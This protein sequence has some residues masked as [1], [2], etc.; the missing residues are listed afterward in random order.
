MAS[1][2]GKWR[3]DQVLVICPGSQTTMA[4]LGCAE[5]TP[6][7]NRLPTRIF[8]D[9]DADEWRPYYTY[10]R[11]KASHAA[12]PGANGDAQ[13]AAEG[14]QKNGDDEDEYEWVEDP[15]SAEGAVYPIQ[16]TVSSSTPF[17]Q[18][19]VSRAKS[20]FIH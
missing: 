18:R 17:L 4:Q 8:K 16:G 10:K 14:A 3:E 15:D 19:R 11:R 5:L 7:A 9:D 1:Q 12:A 2:T 13:Q 6:P 20:S